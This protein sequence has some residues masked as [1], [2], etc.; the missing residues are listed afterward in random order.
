MPTTRRYEDQKG[1]QLHKFMSSWALSGP[2]GPKKLP[3]GI[4]ATWDTQ[5]P[6][7]PTGG[8]HS[9][10]VPFL[11][12]GGKNK[13]QE[14]WL[15]SKLVLS[16]PLLPHLE[17]GRRDDT[18]ELQFQIC[19]CKVTIKIIATSPFPAKVTSTAF[20]TTPIS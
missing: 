12:R 15:L 8:Y 17:N 7:L 2:H 18:S 19:C 5:E 6:T 20:M 4:E 9:P 14:T 11:G 1:W 16:V 13:A 3:C 10:G